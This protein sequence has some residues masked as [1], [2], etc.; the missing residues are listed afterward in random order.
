[1]ALITLQLN[2]FGPEVQMWQNFLIGEGFL[3]GIADKKFGPKTKTATEAFQKAHGLKADGIVGAKTYTV[4]IGQGLDVVA[5]SAAD[6]LGYGY[7]PVPSFR[8]LASN[9][10]RARVFGKFD[11]LPAP[12]ASNPEAIKILGNWESSNIVKVNLPQLAKVT[13]GRYTSM[14]FHRLAADQLSELWQAWEQAN[15]LDRVKTYEGAFVPRFARGSR[16]VLSNHAFGSAFDINYAW[17][18]LGHQPALVHQEGSVREL[19]QLA[20]QFGFY[21]GGHFSSRPDGM[22][23][24]VAV[25]QTKPT[26]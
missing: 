26:P 22:H 24:E 8:P 16:T 9:Q 11:F 14:Q 10:E 12:T 19:V 4:A 7:P 13:G 21:W 2:S 17:N 25:L 18:K 6:D 23:F 20:N 3:L 1:M 15:L 5:P